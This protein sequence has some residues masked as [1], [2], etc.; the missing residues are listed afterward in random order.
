MNGHSDHIVDE[1]RR[2]TTLES[3]LLDELQE[4]LNEPV[5]EEQTRWM[6]STLNVFCETVEREFQLQSD[7]YLQAVLD[8][9]PSRESQVAGLREKNERLL[10]ELQQLNDCFHRLALSKRI[11]RRT[12]DQVRSWIERYARHRRAE[13]DLL[14]D[15][16]NADVGT[17]E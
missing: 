9:F 7:G 10:R 2:C 8:E 15:S 6:Q 3:L 16:V 14:L 1:L 4:L 11:P 5:D 13:R 17:G 12:R